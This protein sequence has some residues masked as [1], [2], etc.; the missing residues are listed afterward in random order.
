MPLQ[1][2]Q[3]IRP[4]RASCKLLSKCCCPPLSPLTPK[5]FRISRHSALSDVNGE[6][7]QLRRCGRIVKEQGR[8]EKGIQLPRGQE[9]KVSGIGRARLAVRHFLLVFCSLIPVTARRTTIPQ[10]KQELMLAK[11]SPSIRKC[12]E[13][14]ALSAELLLKATESSKFILDSQHSSPLWHKPQ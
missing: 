7:G 9:A 1:C 3:S 2:T 5:W 11:F 6:R 10:H 8:Q 12:G 14:V 4:S 13:C